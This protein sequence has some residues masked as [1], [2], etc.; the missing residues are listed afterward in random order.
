ML[1]LVIYHVFFEG[2]LHFRF[3]CSL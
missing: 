3:H 1:K 2:E